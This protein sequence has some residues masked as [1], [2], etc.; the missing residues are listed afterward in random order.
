MGDQ[1]KSVLDNI[2][3]EDRAFP[4]NPQ[5]R[6]QF[7]K[8]KKPAKSI[9]GAC[10]HCGN[11]IY[12]YPLLLEGTRPETERSCDCYVPTRNVQQQLLN[13]KEEGMAK[14]GK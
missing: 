12:G 3:V 14:E 2:P 11:P 6:E 1:Q 5:L 13:T 9:V 8:L 10:K 7:E 4:L